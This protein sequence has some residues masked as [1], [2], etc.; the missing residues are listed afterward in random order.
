L[1]PLA[2]IIKLNQPSI[3]LLPVGDVAEAQ[4]VTTEFDDDEGN[5]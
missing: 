1:T 2:N 5:K 4:D 3:V